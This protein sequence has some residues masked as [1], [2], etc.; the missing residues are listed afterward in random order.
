MGSY[1]MCLGYYNMV[2]NFSWKYFLKSADHQMVQ[3][4]NKFCT[5]V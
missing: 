2:L 4:Q 5:F 1:I 3:Y